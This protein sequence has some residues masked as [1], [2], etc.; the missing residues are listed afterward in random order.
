MCVFLGKWPRVKVDIV[1]VEESLRDMGGLLW[2]A[3]VFRISR[4]VDSSQSDLPSMPISKVAILNGQSQGGHG[5]W[6][7]LSSQKVLLLFLSLVLRRIGD[8]VDF[9]EV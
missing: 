7:R 2:I 3:W 1:S 8:S 4:D 6:V 5:D 9:V